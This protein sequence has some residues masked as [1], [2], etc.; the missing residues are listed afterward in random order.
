MTIVLS[1]VYLGAMFCI[2]AF[3]VYSYLE[4]DLRSS[5]LDQT[6]VRISAILFCIL[7]ITVV[8]LPVY[9]GIKNLISTDA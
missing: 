8:S 9:F 5:A 2:I 7:E 1:L 6:T 3:P 4:G